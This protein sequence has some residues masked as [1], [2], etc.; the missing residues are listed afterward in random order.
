MSQQEIAEI[1]EEKRSSYA[2]WE[3]GTI[4][5]ADVLY[6]IAIYYKVPIGYFFEDS[7]NPE[8]DKAED[9]KIY[10]KELRDIKISLKNLLINLDN[11]QS[12]IR[13]EV[14]GYG[15]Y[16]V[17]NSVGFDEDAYLKAKGLVDKLCGANLQVDEKQGN[18][19]ALSKKSKRVP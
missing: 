7:E 5:R 15:Q 1:L 9:D 17:L 4:P 13:A 18:Q 14:R 3:K 10:L 2:E 6:K 8:I 19:N 11:G 12:A 16:L